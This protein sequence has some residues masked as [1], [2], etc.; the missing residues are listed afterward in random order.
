MIKKTNMIHK[1]LPIDQ[2][3]CHVMYLI[4]KEGK[5]NDC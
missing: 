5:L 2:L 3:R 4:K 1:D